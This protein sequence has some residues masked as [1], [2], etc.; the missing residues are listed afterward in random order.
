MLRHNLQ[1]RRA[2]GLTGDF[3]SFF[4][5]YCLKK[6]PD[7]RYAVLNRKYKPVGMVTDDQIAYDA[8]PVL[9]SMR[10][11]RS[12]AAELSWNG[13]ASPDEVFLYNDATNPMTSPRDMR[14]YLKR[15]E[16]LTKFKIKGA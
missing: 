3:L 1:R 15:I 12:V 5:P 11:T 13:D 7:G 9:V 4:M 10:V 16:R 8:H 2:M 14:A 6:Q